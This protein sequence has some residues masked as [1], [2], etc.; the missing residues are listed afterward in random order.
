MAVLN[1]LSVRKM[2]ERSSRCEGI[3][4]ENPLSGNECTINSW[5][6][7][8]GSF[9][10]P[11]Y[12]DKERRRVTAVAHKHWRQTL[13][14]IRGPWNV[15]I[16]VNWKYKIQ[17]KIW[18]MYYNKNDSWHNILPS[19]AHSWIFINETYKINISLTLKLYWYINNSMLKNTNIYR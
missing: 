7:K 10:S 4:L 12:Q 17:K 1:N 11:S 19:K 9:M 3:T 6:R 13:L 18:G 8:N 16:P 14:W 5:A 2:E 15:Q